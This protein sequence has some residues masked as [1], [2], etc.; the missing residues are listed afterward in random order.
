MSDSTDKKLEALK[1][2]LAKKNNEIRGLTKELAEAN[3][4]LMWS[5]MRGTDELPVGSWPK[6]GEEDL[7]VEEPKEQTQEEI[8]GY[9]RQQRRYERE[10]A[11]K[12]EIKLEEL[13][14]RLNSASKDLIERRNRSVRRADELAAKLG[15]RELCDC[16][17]HLVEVRSPCMKCGAPQCCP[18]CCDKTILE[19]ALEKTRNDCKEALN[20]RDDVLRDTT[21]ALYQSRGA[22]E[23]LGLKYALR[24]SG[25]VHALSNEV[26]ALREKL[27]KVEKSGERKKKGG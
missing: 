13:G 15:K 3:A 6:A 18:A 2:K 25:A 10:R 14:R 17:G 5:R 27:A 11:D 22:A 1:L 9:L 21:D 24:P 20:L 8:M 4:D 16:C 26:E 23:R 19:L 7:P 12:A